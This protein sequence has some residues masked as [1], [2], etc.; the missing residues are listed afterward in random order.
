MQNCTVLTLKMN[1]YASSLHHGQTYDY[2]HIRLVI[3]RVKVCVKN[4]YRKILEL[5]INLDYEQ[6]GSNS[7]VSERSGLMRCDAVSLRGKFPDLLKA[8]VL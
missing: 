7:C 3:C 4:F 5:K 1:C 8:N 2:L 6:L